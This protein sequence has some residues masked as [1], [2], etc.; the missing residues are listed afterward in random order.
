M[1]ARKTI[2]SAVHD[3]Q[4][5]LDQIRVSGETIINLRGTNRL[6]NANEYASIT[7]K[8][9]T[10]I[11]GLL[12]EEDYSISVKKA[13]ADVFDI[14][15][16]LLKDNP[17]PLQK[18]DV[19]NTSLRWLT[20]LWGI[21]VRTD[22]IQLHKDAI[23]GF[24]QSVKRK[25][26]I[27]YIQSMIAYAISLLLQN[28]EIQAT[29]SFFLVVLLMKIENISMRHEGIRQLFHYVKSKFPNYYEI[30]VLFYKFSDD[31]KQFATKSAFLSTK[32]T[33]K[34]LCILVESAK[35]LVNDYYIPLGK[36]IFLA[37]TNDVLQLL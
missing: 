18:Q 14:H 10:N 35:T 24:Q 32:L 17:L 31:V 28:Q 3:P 22:E 34:M 36:N 26:S 37:N 5:D 20:N 9:L 25:N 6:Y 11:F 33:E 2:E 21:R 8:G 7:G 16:E 1:Y 13:I 29:K 4:Q 23:I 19:V 12:K 30:T 27:F 15:T